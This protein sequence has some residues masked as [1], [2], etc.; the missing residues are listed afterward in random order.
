MQKILITGAGGQVGQKVHKTLSPY[1]EVL[2]LSRNELDVTSYFSLKKVFKSFKP[3]IVIN[4][5]AYTKVDEAERNEKIATEVNFSAVKL[6]NELCAA[7]NSFM[8]HFSTDYVFDGS[9]ARSYGESDRTNPLNVYGQTKLAADNHLI[10]H[11][12]KYAIF[13][14]AWVYDDL[15]VNFPKKILKAAKNNDHI[16]VVNDQFGT[17]TSAKFISKVV[18]K[19][20]EQIDLQNCINYNGLFNL[21]PNG[22][23]S[24]FEFAAYLLSSAEKIGIELSCKSKDLI[25]VSTNHIHQ[26]ALR[27]RKVTLANDKIQKLIGTEFADW[28]IGVDTFVKQ[29]NER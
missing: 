23:S 3:D 4:A 17:P 1:F 14:L 16:K 6:L 10:Q 7:N 13:R 24:W 5:A 2:A 15:G 22:C 28:R 21:V 29:I 8:I 26:L 11:A 9:I 25:P 18:L 20:I 19:F 12:Q 27:P